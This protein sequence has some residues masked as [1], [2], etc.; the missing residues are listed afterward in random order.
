MGVEAWGLAFGRT[1]TMRRVGILLLLG[2]LYVFAA[3]L[4]VG[5]RALA[6]SLCLTPG[7]GCG[8]AMAA[9]SNTAGND[10]EDEASD[11]DE[12][13]GESS[14]TTSTYVAKIKE[15]SDKVAS[16]KAG[17]KRCQQSNARLSEVKPTAVVELGA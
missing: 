4:G 2:S 3:G 6:G 11:L 16:A 1:R 9:G 8:F 5:R 12:L 7:G 13:L 14:Q 10:E 17:E 15:L